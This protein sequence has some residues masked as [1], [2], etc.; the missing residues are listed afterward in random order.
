[1]SVYDTKTKSKNPIWA[2]IAIAFVAVVAAFTFGRYVA[3]PAIAENSKEYILAQAEARGKEQA[4]IKAAAI[5]EQVIKANA[6]K[7]TTALNQQRE[8]KEAAERKAAEEKAAVDALGLIPISEFNN[9]KDVGSGW[10]IRGPRMR[11]IKSTDENN[12]P[13]IESMFEFVLR[14]SNG[15]RPKLTRFVVEVYNEKKEFMFPGVVDISATD[16]GLSYVRTGVYELNGTPTYC[17]VSLSD[18]NTVK[19]INEYPSDR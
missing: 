10:E 16:A 15:I 9:W 18:V 12:R 1:M 2:V 19:Y 13:K 17:R 14:R 5:R 4:Q 7:A 6:A 3:P 11:N 8:Q